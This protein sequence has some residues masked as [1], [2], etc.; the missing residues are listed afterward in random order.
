MNFEQITK[1]II[2]KRVDQEVEKHSLLM[3]VSEVKEIL[4]IH[5][6][7]QIYKMLNNDQ[8]PGAKKIPGLGWRINRDIFFIW[9][10]S[11]SDLI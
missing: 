6:D 3:K 8:I 10:Y 4:D 1:E 9:L 5:D 7:G 11:N 2:K